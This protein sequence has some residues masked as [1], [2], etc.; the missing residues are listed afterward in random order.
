[1]KLHAMNRCAFCG[2]RTSL[3]VSRLITTGQEAPVCIDTKA[4]L[5]RMRVL[6][7]ADLARQ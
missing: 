1:M 6:K 5:R 3:R 7:D 4:C 2:A